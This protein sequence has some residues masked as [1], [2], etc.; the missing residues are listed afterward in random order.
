MKLTTPST[1]QVSL[2]LAS[3]KRIPFRPMAKRGSRTS[4][5]FQLPGLVLYTL[6]SSITGML[7][8][9]NKSFNFR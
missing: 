2:A 4:T 7:G 8:I 9:A 1:L 5:A 6:W 3:W